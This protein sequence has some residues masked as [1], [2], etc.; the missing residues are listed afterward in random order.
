MRVLGRRYLRGELG[1]ACCGVY[2][3]FL[4]GCGCFCGLLDWVFCVGKRDEIWM[5]DTN[6]SKRMR[7]FAWILR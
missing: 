4:T 7:G 3:L 6:L 2:V 5:Y 1:V